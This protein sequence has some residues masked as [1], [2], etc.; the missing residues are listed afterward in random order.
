MRASET[1]T[2]P[3]KQN[4]PHDHGLGLWKV[5]LNC[6]RAP[7]SCSCTMHTAHS[8]ELL[9]FALSWKQEWKL[10]AALLNGLCPGLCSGSCPGS[11]LSLLSPPFLPVHRPASVQGAWTSGT[12]G[13]LFLCTHKLSLSI[14]LVPRW[15]QAL[16]YL[17]DELFTQ[18]PLSV[19][20]TFHQLCPWS[21]CPK[22]SITQV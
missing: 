5:N 11:V 21:L 3:N 6:W 20:I 1:C 10:A 12:R 4:N 15:F 16:L 13:L 22:S 7:D 17:S 18:P 19:F 9:H 2:L 8:A 14:P